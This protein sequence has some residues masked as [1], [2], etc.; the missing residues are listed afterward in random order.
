MNYFTLSIIILFFLASGLE[1][2]HARWLQ[3]SFLAL[4]GLLN[5]VVYFMGK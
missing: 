5:V 1:A 4:S 3:A 2:I